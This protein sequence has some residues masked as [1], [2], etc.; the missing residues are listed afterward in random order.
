[1]TQAY[2]LLADQQ[3]PPI[4][5]VAT[6]IVFV[7]LG[8]L[9]LYFFRG[10]EALARRSLQRKYRGL[11]IHDVPKAGD[12]V[13]TYHTYHGLIAW[14]TQIPHQVALPPDDARRLLGRLLRFNLTWGLPSYGA[15]FIPPIAILNYV[16]QRKL[17]ATGEATTLAAKDEDQTGGAP[18]HARA[19]QNPY[20][21]PRTQTDSKVSDRP[22]L[23]FAIGWACAG[24]CGVFLIAVAIGLVNGEYGSAVGGLVIAALFGWLA[25]NWLGYRGAPP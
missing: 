15:L 18:T 10:Y 13:I 7:V 23:H 19:A 6:I 24:L 9:V 22:L 12:V 4:A 3:I 17:I 8:V 11:T 25:R 14:V 21:S 1:M 2:L 20:D 5:I 16:A